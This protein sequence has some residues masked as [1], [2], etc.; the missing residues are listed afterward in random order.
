MRSCG[1]KRY[2]DQ[3]TAQGNPEGPVGTHDATFS[4]DGTKPEALASLFPDQLGTP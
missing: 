4:K 1:A 2:Q 3:L